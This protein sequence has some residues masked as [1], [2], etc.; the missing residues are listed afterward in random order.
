MQTR[1]GKRL[2]DSTGGYLTTST[3]GTETRRKRADLTSGTLGRRP[4]NYYIIWLKVKIKIFSSRNHNYFY[5]GLYHLNLCP[6]HLVEGETYRFLGVLSKNR[7]EWGL[8]DLAC[9]RSGTTI[10]PFYDS[11]G[12]EAV[13]F[14]IRQTELSTVCCELKQLDGLIKLK[15][16]KCDMLK[17]IICFDEVP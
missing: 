8:C 13:S 12:A 5:I 3:W 4:T 15:Q 7:L 17:T 9:I 14:I 16:T 10:V 11:L 2:R 1:C 6:E